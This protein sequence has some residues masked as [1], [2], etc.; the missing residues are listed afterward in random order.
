M[1]MGQEMLGRRL[2]Q[3]YQQAVLSKRGRQSRKHAASGLDP[4]KIAL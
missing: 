4:S 3:L 2:C 1:N